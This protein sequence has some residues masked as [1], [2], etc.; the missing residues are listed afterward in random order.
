MS[1]LNARFISHLESG[2]TVL[3]ATRRQARIIRRLYDQAQL[4][5]GRR[6]WP[7]ADALPVDAWLGARWREAAERDRDLPLLLTEGQ[8]T[9]WWRRQAE[10]H[11]DPELVPTADLAGAARHA[12]LRLVLHGGDLGLLDNEILTRDQRQFRDWASQVTQQMA[13]NGRADP[14]ALACDLARHVAALDVGSPLL[15]AGF[16]APFPAL[17]ALLERLAGQGW[18]VQVAPVAAAARAAGFTAAADPVAETDAWVTWARACLEKDPDARLAVIVPDLAARRAWLERRLA[19]GLQPEL[20]LPGAREHDRLFDLAGGEP[21]AALDIG[22][23]ALDCLAVAGPRA[24]FSVVS[25]LLRS[26]YV[27]PADKLDDRVRFDIELRRVGTFGWPP[28]ALARRAGQAGCTALADAI[29]ATQRSLVDG[30]RRRSVDAWARSF[31]E[32]LASW[33]WPGAGPL[34]SDEFQAADALRQ[35]L[36]EFANLGE[37]APALTLDEA[38]TEFSLV[39]AEPFQPERGDPSLWVF[40]ALEPPGVEF[41][42]LWISGM[43]A[44]N[45]PRAVAQDPFLPLSLQRRLGMPGTSAEDALQHAARTVAAWQGSADEVVFSWPLHVDDAAAEPSRLVPAGLEAIEPSV[46]VP[47]RAAGLAATTELELLEPDPAPP[48]TGK[49]RGGARVLELQAKCPFRAF[50]EL[51]LAA[52]PLEEPALGIDARVRGNLLHAALEF[53]W[54]ELGGRA[55]LVRLSQEQLDDLVTRA[56]D[57]ATAA[58]LPPELGGRAAQ[59]EREWQRSAIERLIELDRSRGDFE[60][61]DVEAGL[62]TT[63]AGLALELRVDRIDRTGEGLVILDY[64]TGRATTSQWRGARPDA[65]QLP[66][67]AVMAGADVKAIAFAKAG[68]H[69]AA[70]KG[71]GAS[72]GLLPG[73]DAAEKFRLADREE[74]GVAWPELQRRWAG[75]LAALARAHLLGIAQVDPKQPQTCRNCHLATLCRVSPDA[76]LAEDGEGDD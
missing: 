33:G 42:G 16:D 8:A 35:R 44:S 25:R 30:P 31:G 23:S 21:L 67:Y 71:I 74:A 19:A 47:T 55:G 12:W 24:T 39:L 37:A 13:R 60:V 70:F 2:G 22:Q 66:L 41:D 46:P 14:G 36:A 65:P 64:K 1:E 38:R 32:A 34:A 17:K 62:S 45:W 54:R 68:A 56:L 28:A 50:A 53:V 18:Q 7:S 61:V 29:G 59:I 3:T 9:W 52:R 76:Q 69:E 75:W 11:I 57:A 43:T 63:L 20:E 5:R 15:L 6:C 58:E 10:A 48:L 51:R 26:R 49:A 73:L 40:D 72:A 27:A 4:A